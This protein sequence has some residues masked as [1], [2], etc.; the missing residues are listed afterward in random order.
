M[1]SKPAVVSKQKLPVLKAGSSTSAPETLKDKTKKLTQQVNGKTLSKTI[2]GSNSILPGFVGKINAYSIPEERKTD[3]MIKE[4]S[5]KYLQKDGSG[6]DAKKTDPLVVALNRLYKIH[7]KIIQKENVLDRLNRN[8]QKL[9]MQ[10][11]NRMHRE[12]L[13][14]LTGRPVIDKEEEKEVKK[15]VKK[16]TKKP[17]KTTKGNKKKAVGEFL[18]REA[19]AAIGVAGVATSAVVNRVTEQRPTATQIPPTTTSPM[20]GDVKSNLDLMTKALK[21]QGITDPKL[22]N[23]TL[24]NVMKETGG[25]INVEEDLSGYANTSNERIRKIFGDRVSKKSDEELNRIKK[26]PKQFAELVYGKDSGM[27][28][29]NTEIGDAYKYRG[30]GAIG[31]TGK[32]N[33]AE[34]SKDI[35]GDDRL[36][37]NPDLLQD[38]EISAKTSAWFMKKHTGAMAKRMGLE[39]PL[40]QEQ[41]NLLATSTIAGQVIK[42]GQGFLGQE[43]LGKVQAYSA[44]IA[45]IPAQVTQTP[46]ATQVRVTSNFGK[47]GNVMTGKGEENHAGIDLGGKVGDP[48]FSTGAGTVSI[49]KADPNGYGNWIIVNH[50]SG[51]QTYYAHLS[52]I[53]IQDGQKVESGTMIGKVGNTGR[54]TGPHLHY[55]IMKDGKPVDP[56]QES[57]PTLAPFA[58]AMTGTG[59]AGDQATMV[60]ST[61]QPN[62]ASMSVENRDLKQTAAQT[63]VPVVINNVTTNQVGGTSTAQTLIVAT[64]KE[65]LSRESALMW[66]QRG[67]N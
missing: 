50:G 41:A 58:V 44:Q 18:L 64:T 40:T 66:T 59:I 9:E 47:R 36:V 62:V 46:T 49:P 48:V 2:A 7:K 4:E 3:E 27:G 21:E 11:K 30:R 57:P 34:A 53:S 61:Q 35:F 24:A 13:A 43:A 6:V 31:L 42:P 63:S 55:Q 45:G 8:I 12:L 37:K 65:I 14:V 23:A 39:G 51:V 19:P 16:T 33:Y 38:P 15:E 17:K 32:A 67:Y 26:D 54:S 20:T 60:A 10:S 22:I 29:G 1:A 56:Q 28:L 5:S 52:E 25:K